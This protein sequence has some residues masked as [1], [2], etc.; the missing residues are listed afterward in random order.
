MCA[1]ADAHVYIYVRDPK[2]STRIYLKMIKKIAGY[3]FNLLLLINSFVIYQ[4][5]TYRERDHEHTAI[6]NNVKDNEISRNKLN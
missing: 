5:Q 6:Y 3:I 2:N 1:H 4:Q